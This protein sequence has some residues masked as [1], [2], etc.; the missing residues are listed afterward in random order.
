M[1]YN[2]VHLCMLLHSHQCETVPR[3]PGAALLCP[4]NVDGCEGVSLSR[5]GVCVC[6]DAIDSSLAYAPPSNLTLTLPPQTLPPNTTTQ[7]PLI[8]RMF[9]NHLTSRRSGQVPMCE[10]HPEPEL[11]CGLL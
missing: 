11:R 5:V 1:V 8:C 10:S 4:C 3:C 6:V 7:A 2:C 9:A